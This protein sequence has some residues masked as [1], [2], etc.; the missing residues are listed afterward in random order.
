MSRFDL[1][2]FGATGFTGTYILERLITSPYY[3]DVSFAVAGRNESKVREVLRVVEKKTGRDLKEVKVILADVADIESLEK[4]AK[5]ARVVI[6]AVG[7]Y[8]LYGEA[9]VRAAILNGASHLDISGEQTWIEKMEEKYSKLAED[10]GVYVVSAC[11]WD[12]IPA[13]L[14]VK[15]LK[16]NF[17]G[18]LNHVETFV[19]MKSGSSGYSLNT[20]TYNSLLLG[21]K[22]FPFDLMKPKTDVSV[23]KGKITPKF[24][25]PLSQIPGIPGPQSYAIPFMGSDKS[26]IDRSQIYEATQK[27]IKPCHVATYAKLSSRISAILIGAWL[28]V[29]SILVHIPW[30]LRFLQNHPDL[31]SFNVFKKDGPSEEQI[32]EASFVLW[33]FGYGYTKEKLGFEH[34]GEPTKM[35]LATCKG[36]D[37]GYVSTSGCILSAALVLLKDVDSLP[38]RMLLLHVSCFISDTIF[39]AFIIPVIFLPYYCGYSMGVLN[40]F[41]IPMWIQIYFGI[42]T[43]T[44]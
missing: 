12:S 31:C 8:T 32:R 4:M 28:A 40:Y 18:D 27:S 17:D 44:S 7:P 29:I 14:G 34:Q 6:N 15:F 20:G 37:A 42:T 41:G 3:Q 33:L 23:V 43:S 16:N 22:S 11:G 9:V 39:G 25:L 35:V 10:A 36:P 2:I 1:V 19:E 30:T 26:I 13:D 5:R 24:R 21:V 38:E